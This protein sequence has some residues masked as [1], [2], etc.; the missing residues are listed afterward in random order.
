[1]NIEF[2]DPLLRPRQFSL[3]FL[4]FFMIVIIWDSFVV[5]A[6]GQLKYN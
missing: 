1:M 6:H 5:F 3:I 4:S 2:F